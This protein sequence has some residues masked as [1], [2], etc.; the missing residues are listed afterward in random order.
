[1]QLGPSMLFDSEVKP[2]ESPN[3]KRRMSDRRRIG[4]RD[5]YGTIINRH[6]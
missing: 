2:R 6:G 3:G 5:C 1:M 4:S